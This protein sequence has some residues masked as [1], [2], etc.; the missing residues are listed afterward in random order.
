MS[1]VSGVLWQALAYR[2]IEFVQLM[3]RQYGIAV[4]LDHLAM[5]LDSLNDYTM[6][7][8]EEALLSWNTGS[9][10][11]HGTVV[12]DNAPLCVGKLLNASSVPTGTEH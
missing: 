10:Y 3:E 2:F 5:V 12:K 1:T 11:L 4:E 8:P 7:T 9:M 6:L